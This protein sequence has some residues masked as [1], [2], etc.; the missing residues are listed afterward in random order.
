MEKK[1]LCFDCGIIQIQSY[2]I[3]ERNEGN[4]NIPIQM[5]TLI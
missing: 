1:M 5:Q 3:H 4:G 2:N